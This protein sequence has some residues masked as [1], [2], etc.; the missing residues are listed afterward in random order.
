MAV[1]YDLVA[2]NAVFLDIHQRG[3]GQFLAADESYLV[4]EDAVVQVEFSV[5]TGKAHHHAYR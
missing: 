2:R 1:G 3:I 5:I 4:E